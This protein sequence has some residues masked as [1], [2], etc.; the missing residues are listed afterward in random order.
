MTRAGLLT[1]VMF[2]ALAT[3]ADASTPAAPPLA[4]RWQY[5]QPPDIEGEVLDLFVS[6]G[7][8]RG[9]MNGLE[10]AGEHG[11]F[12]YVAELEGL[13]V[14]PDGG[15]RFEVG[16]RSLFDRRPALSELGGKGD[17]GVVRDRMRFS[18]RLESGDL[19]L[20]CAGAGGSCPDST[21]RFKRITAS[22]KPPAASRDTTAFA[23]AVRFVVTDTTEAYE[24]PLGSSLGLRVRREPPMGWVVSVTAK[25]SEADSPNL[26]Y[27]SRSWRGP[28]PTDVFAWS[29]QRRFFPDE[30]ILPVYGHPYEIRVRLVDCRTSGAGDDAV[31]EAGTIEVAWRRAPVERVSDDR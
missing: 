16:E 10:R 23:V 27:H 28:Y 18:G 13:E 3:W 4:G 24:C 14:S 31:F 12:Y 29:H 11:L 1:V 2:A 5:L 30:R 22:P 7:R 6:S 26:L 21:L 25:S 20:R 9:V 19:V 8:W 17:A 15:I